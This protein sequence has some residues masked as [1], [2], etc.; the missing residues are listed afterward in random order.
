MSTEQSS[1]IIKSINPNAFELLPGRLQ[2]NYPHE[3]LTENQISVAVMLQ[4]A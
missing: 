4:G 1:G 3:H 2:W